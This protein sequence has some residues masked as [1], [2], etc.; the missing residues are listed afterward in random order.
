MKVMSKMSFPDIWNV[1]TERSVKD[2]FGAPCLANYKTALN[3]LKHLKQ[4]HNI[5]AIF[6][7]LRKDVER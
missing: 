6:S 1:N 5:D 2:E 7:E 4:F 3:A